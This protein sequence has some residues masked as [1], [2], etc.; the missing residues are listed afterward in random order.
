MVRKE[1]K[2]GDKTVTILRGSNFD[3]LVYDGLSP[4]DAKRKAM[5]SAMAL[6]PDWRNEE[7]I[8][9][10]SC[11]SDGNY[12]VNANPFFEKYPNIRPERGKRAE[13]VK[14]LIKPESRVEAGKRKSR[15][16]DDSGE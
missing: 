8:A 6:R 15:R 11:D 5:E 14:P 10:Y 12:T 16:D 4:E 3:P 2:T 13:R 7:V 1:K 9:D